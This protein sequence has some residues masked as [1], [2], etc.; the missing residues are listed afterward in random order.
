[1]EFRIAMVGGIECRNLCRRGKKLKITPAN[2]DIQLKGG[3]RRRRKNHAEKTKAEAEKK[4][5]NLTT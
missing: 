1:M 5:R 2:L 4:K 3:S